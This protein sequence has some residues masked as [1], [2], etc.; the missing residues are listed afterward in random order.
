MSKIGYARISTNEQTLD[1]QP[2]ALRQAGCLKTS[3]DRVSGAADE[4]K[5]LEDAL[6]YQRIAGTQVV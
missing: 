5:G 2:D 4:R 1:L 6:A 3:T